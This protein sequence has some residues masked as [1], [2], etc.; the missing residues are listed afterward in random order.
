MIVGLSIHAFTIIHV[1]ISLIAI[2]SG[3]MVLIGMLGALYFQCAGSDRAIVLESTGSACSCAD[4]VG[5]AVSY[6]A[7]RGA[8]RFPRARIYRGV[9][10]PAGSRGVGAL[11]Q[12]FRV[13]RS[14][15]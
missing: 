6:R 13:T 1:I 15:G 8:G 12:K 10:V 4:T 9:Q 2:A 5:T 14:A 11:A 7:R 3:I